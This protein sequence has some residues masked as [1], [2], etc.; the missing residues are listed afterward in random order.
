MSDPDTY[1]NLDGDK[2]LAPS[3]FPVYLEDSDDPVPSLAD[4]SILIGGAVLYRHAN[5]PWPLCA[6]CSSPLVPL[7]QLNISSPNTPLELRDT[8]PMPPPPSVASEAGIRSPGVDAAIPIIQLCV[9]P[10]EECF[11]TSIEQEGDSWLVRLA[12]VPPAQDFDA[13]PGD[14]ELRLRSATR[15]SSDSRKILARIAAE[16]LLT[17][18]FRLPPDCRERLRCHGRL[19]YSRAPRLKICQR[20]AQRS[21][22][23]F[24]RES[25]SIL[26]AERSLIERIENDTGFLPLRVVSGWTRGKDETLHDTLLWDQYHT[27]DSREVFQL[28]N[29]SAQGW[30]EDEALGIMAMVGPC[31]IQQCR[32][33]PEVL[34]LSMSW[35][36]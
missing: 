33:H 12:S 7:V 35:H 11:Q 15:I 31:V 14:R 32:T 27:D 10:Q 21:Q 30:E 22:Q 28:G 17:N 18:L 5:E 24:W 8:I 25:E 23:R 6:T 20:R 29:V 34:V 19:I 16:S 36:V 26:V 13:H 3:F 4:H 1:T 9:C 2:F